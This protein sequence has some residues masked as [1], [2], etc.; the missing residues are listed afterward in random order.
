[1]LANL[2]LS[3]GFLAQRCC[4]AGIG[5]PSCPALAQEAPVAAGAARP[6]VVCLWIALAAAGQGGRSPA[7]LE[8]TERSQPKSPKGPVAAFTL[9]SLP[10]AG[11][12]QGAAG[13]GSAVPEGKARLW[14]RPGSGSHSRPGPRLPQS[15]ARPSAA[16]LRAA[17]AAEPTPF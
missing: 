10:G 8:E 9:L 15:P 2:I 4:A 13:P 16:S 11:L 6:C 7:G 5:A 3:V 14:A 12:V 17:G 1:M